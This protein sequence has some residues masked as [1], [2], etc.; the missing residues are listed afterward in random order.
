MPT[1][2]HENGDRVLAA[3]ATPTAA[4]K[5]HPRLSARR[6]NAECE[7]ANRRLT[8]AFLRIVLHLPRDPE[9]RFAWT[10]RRRASNP[11]P[12]PSQNLV[13]YAQAAMLEAL[14]TDDAA[15]IESTALEIN[16]LGS[17]ILS[18]MLTPYR[19]WAN[20]DVSITSAGLDAL[21]EISEASPAI[22]LALV[23]KSTGDVE[24]AVHGSV[25]AIGALEP[26]CQIARRSTASVASRPPLHAT[27]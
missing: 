19:I 9:P 17:E 7:E 13:E 5:P 18:A 12:A 24:R 6:L 11:L 26:F 2:K 14:A 16:A 1:I 21:R 8:P 15:V 25:R 27:R 4:T 22:A 10:N 3:H 20:G 23:T